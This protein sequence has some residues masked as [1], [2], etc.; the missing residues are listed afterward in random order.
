MFQVTFERSASRIM[1]ALL[2]LYG[3][4]QFCYACG[5][6]VTPKNVGAFK[7]LDDGTIGVWHSQLPCLMAL[8]N[9]TNFTEDSP[10]DG[11]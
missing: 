3:R 6:K 5:H 8:I 9:I 1:W 10:S 7:K 2:G 11:K 4:R